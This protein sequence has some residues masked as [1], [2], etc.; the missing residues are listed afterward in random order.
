[1]GAIDMSRIAEN[2]YGDTPAPYHGTPGFKEPT[3]SRE[4]AIKFKTHAETLRAQALA[5][6]AAAPST[7]DEIAARLGSTVLAVRPRISELAKMG[8]IERVPNVRRKNASGMS[9]AVWRKA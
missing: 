5:E 3:T 1:M 6:I 2:A 4:A 9:A 7:A 8:K